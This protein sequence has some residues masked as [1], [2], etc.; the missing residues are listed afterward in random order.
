MSVDD[1]RLVIASRVAIPCTNRSRIRHPVCLPRPDCF[2]GW[3]QTRLLSTR[4]E[5]SDVKSRGMLAKYI[6][7]KPLLTRQSLIEI[8]QGLA[9]AL[10]CEKISLL[11]RFGTFNR[12]SSKWW[13][14][15]L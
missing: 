8:A 7:E 14:Q 15:F 12:S 13:I 2:I 10:S 5:G 4:S 9:H 3:L 1:K 6:L 11:A